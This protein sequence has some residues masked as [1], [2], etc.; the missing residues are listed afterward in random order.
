[1]NKQQELTHKAMLY[2]TEFNPYISFDDLKS[3]FNNIPEIR[4][5]ELLF[6]GREFS[7]KSIAKNINSDYNKT[8]KVIDNFLRLGLVKRRIQAYT[9]YKLNH[10]SNIIKSIMW[11]LSHTRYKS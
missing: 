10:D 7:V 11:M 1:M 3:L 6:K 5:I 4:I 2:N 8:K 9:Y